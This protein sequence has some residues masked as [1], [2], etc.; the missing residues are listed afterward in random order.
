MLTV[1]ESAFVLFPDPEAFPEAKVRSLLMFR[2]SFIIAR[3]SMHDV[4]MWE[5]F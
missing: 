2:P 3:L 5:Y 4:T 1:D